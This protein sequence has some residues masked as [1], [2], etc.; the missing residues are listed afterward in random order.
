MTKKYLGFISFLF[1][2]YACNNDLKT[3]GQDLVV[4]G[5]NVTLEEKS[6]YNTATIRLD[7]FPTSCGLYGSNVYNNIPSQIIIGK[8]TDSHGGTTE[9]IPCFQLNIP[10]G[11]PY[12][13]ETATLDS[14]TFRIH[15]AGN[16]WGDTLYNPQKQTF[17]LYQLEKVPYINTDPSYNGLFYNTSNVDYKG[18]KI[19]GTAS[20]LPKVLHINDASFRIDD[21][22]ANEMFEEIRYRSDN[23][24]Y[25][26]EEKFREYF[27][28]LAIVPRADNNSLIALQTQSDS[29]YLEF[30][31]KM[32]DNTQK[33]IKF[34]C[35]LSEYLY[36]TYKTDRSETVFKSLNTQRD[37]VTIDDADFALVQG[38]SGYMTK[39][40]LPTPPGMSN[41][42]TLLKV[43]LELKTEYFPNNEIGYP[44]IVNM[45]LLD[46]RNELT[47]PVQNNSTTAVTGSP[48]ESIISGERYYIFDMTEYYQ[49]IM[50]N[51][52]TD[53]MPEVALIIPNF[54]YS[55]NYLVIKEEPRVK[56]YYANYRQ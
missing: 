9:S 43:Q 30:A 38:L 24:F 44:A 18:G 19:I 40:T 1:L 42:S 29:L 51:P 26:N 7:S 14:A 27:K 35:N 15:F 54:I 22:L 32:G 25:D 6:V 49:S 50:D 12:L 41:Y 21:E 5:N 31:Y 36:N 55:Y 45:Y 48:Q 28:G 52:G 10:A 3:I 16:I 2:I 23:S 4:N 46:D 17:D 47:A 53:I 39:F 33:F 56:F 11:L 20:F 13:G 34:G 8:Y 37:E